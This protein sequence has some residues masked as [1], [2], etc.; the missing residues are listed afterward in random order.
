[1]NQILLKIK[2]SRLV[3]RIIPILFLVLIGLVFALSSEGRFTES[4]NLK[5]ILE[6]TLITGTVATGAVFIFASGNVNIAMGASTAL[7]ATLSTMIYE[8]TGS[9]IAMMVSAV[10]MGIILMVISALLSTAL[11]VRVMFVTIVMMTLLASI[12]RAIIGGATL[13]LPFEMTSALKNANFPVIAF[14]VFFILCVIVF[15]FTAVGRKLKFL[16]SNVV[17]AEQSGIQLNIMLIVAFLIAGIG[18]GVGATMLIVRTGSIS[19]TTAGSLNMD[20]VLAIVLGGMSIF[21]GSRSSIFSGLIGALTVT[22]LNNGLLM[23]GVS[24]TV[25]QGIRGILFLIL[26][27]SSQK[28]PKGLPAP[29][30]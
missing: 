6:Q 26:V 11:Q 22:V 3:S 24:A 21:G 8:A 30:Y 23:I 20:V 13:M 29:E 17:C 28:R 19:I 25:L 10:L 16:G 7:V 18:V 4:R 9:V 1:M 12:Q 2:E 15:E 27:F 14:A 5:L